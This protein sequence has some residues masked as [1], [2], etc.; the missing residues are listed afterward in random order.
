[1]IEADVFRVLLESL[2]DE[3]LIVANGYL[4][5]RAFHCRDRS[6]TFY[7]VGSMGLA[8]SIGLGVALARPE[9][10]VVVVDGDGNLLMSLGA[11]AMVANSA[12]KNL[13]HIVIDNQEY[14]S[15]GGQR[16]IAIAEW[17]RLALAAG[18]RNALQLSEELQLRLALD[19]TWAQPGPAFLQV[20]VSTGIEISPRVGRQ[21]EE[22]TIA[23]KKS[24]AS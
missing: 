20:K 7:M 6:N 2:V 1:V 8:S 9:R 17:P 18:Y 10:R 12:A 15:T 19:E 21:P 4:S 5:R 3:A 11:L 16:G 22:I 23:F 24:L 14:A 13:I